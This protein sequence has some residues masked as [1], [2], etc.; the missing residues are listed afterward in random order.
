MRILTA[1]KKAKA[2]LEVKTNTEALQRLRPSPCF[3]QSDQICKTRSFPRSSSVVVFKDICPLG[4]YEQ[5]HWIK[6][7]ASRRPRNKTVSELT[8]HGS[9]VFTSMPSQR[10]KLEKKYTSVA[11]KNIEELRAKYE[12]MGNVWLLAQL[13]QPGR[14]V[15]S[16]LEPTTFQKCLK[17]LLGKQDFNLHKE[18][19]GKLLSPPSLEHCLSCEFE[20]RMEAYKQRRESTIG[21]KA[22]WWNAYNQQRRMMHWLQQVS[23]ANSH[24]SAKVQ[25]ELASLRNEVRQRSRTPTL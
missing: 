15:F 5:S 21:I 9:T 25:R 2:Q 14:S 20:P 18:V 10:W 13:R 19:Q 24:Q 17:Q 11:A 12:V 7:S 16:D 4:C 8:R 23:L 3:V 1:W 6:C 22:A